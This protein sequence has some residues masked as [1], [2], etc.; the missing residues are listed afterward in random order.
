MTSGCKA[1]D[2]GA[3]TGLLGLKL[4]QKNVELTYSS[5]D[6]SSQFVEVLNAH[7]KY[8]ESREVWLGRGEENFPADWKNA[9]ELVTASGVFLKAHMPAP[10][11]DDCVT[12]LKVGG[13]FVTAMRSMY[14]ELGNEEAYRERFD[15]HINA[16]RLE[17][18]N[19][20]NF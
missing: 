6:A 7:P 9:F 15:T 2:V 1:L 4:G 13:Y 10:A 5:C 16:G 11:I 8:C 17:L 14:W 12:A 20:F 19:T 3:G 18:V